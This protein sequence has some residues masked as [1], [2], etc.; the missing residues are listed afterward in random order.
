LFRGE[1]IVFKQTSAESMND[2]FAKTRH[3]RLHY[4]EAGSRGAKAF[5]NAVR[6]SE[7]RHH[8][9]LPAFPGVQGSG[10]SGTGDGRPS[11]FVNP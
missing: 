6:R 8:E 7:A 11:R 10:P 4:L 5:E 3:G 1:P 9:G 2:G